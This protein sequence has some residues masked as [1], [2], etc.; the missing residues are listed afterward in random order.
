VVEIAADHT[1]QNL[2]KHF[3]PICH[4]ISTALASSEPVLIY[5]FADLS[6]CSIFAAAFLI[7]EYKFSIEEALK[8]IKQ[9]SSLSKPVSTF[10][11]QLQQYATLLNKQRKLKEK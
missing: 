2:L 4:E 3:D 8:L 11:F 5:G 6:V 1:N 10:V 7:K 9:K